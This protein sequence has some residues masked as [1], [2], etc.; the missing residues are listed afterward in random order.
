MQTGREI[1]RTPV[2]FWR[3]CLTGCQYEG[4]LEIAVHQIY[5]SKA[6]QRIQMN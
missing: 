3:T 2:T 1:W 6:C 5:R 4:L